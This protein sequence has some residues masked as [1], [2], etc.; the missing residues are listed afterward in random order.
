MSNPLLDESKYKY[1]AVPF[2]QLD[3]AVYMPALEK[4][5]GIARANTEAIKNDPAPP[6]FENTIL[7]LEVSSVEVNKV[8]M[9]Y[10]N[11][12]SAHGDAE[13]HALAKDMM[14][15]IVA[16]ESDVQLDPKL[17]A[18]IKTVH[19]N[20]SS[21]NAEQKMLTEKM[22]LD[23]KRNGA[24]LSDD[25]KAKL[26]AVDEELSTL[27]PQFSENMLKSTNEYFLHVTDESELGGLP[28]S[29]MSAAKDEAKSRKLEGWVFTCHM[30]SSIPFMTYADSAKLRKEMYMA[31]NTRA[32]GGE[33]D[34]SELVKKIAVLRYKRAVLLGYRNHADYTLEQRMAQSPEKVNEFIEYLTKVSRAPA[35]KELADVIAFKKEKTGSD[36]F[37]NWDMGY[38]ANKLKEEKFSFDSEVLRPYFKLEN[39]LEGVFK[40]AEALFDLKFKQI[41]SV[42]VYHEDVTVYEVTKVSDGSFMGLFYGDFFP[43]DTKQSGAWCTRF[44]AQ[45]K[46]GAE[47]IRPHASIVCNFTKPTADKPSLLT[48]GEVNTLFHEFGH[49]L[50]NLLSQVT[51][52]SMSCTNVYRDFVELPSQIFENWIREKES[53]SLFATHYETGELMPDEYIRKIK[54]SDNFLAATYTLRQLYFGSVDMAWFGTNPEKVQDVSAYEMEVTAQTRLMDAVPGTNRSCSFGHIFAGGYAAGYYG[55]KWAEVLDA[56]AFEFFKEEGIFSK[57]VAD[58]FRT[59]ILE[60]GGTAHPMDLYKAFRGREP[61]PE[62]LLRRCELI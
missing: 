22:Y 35:E 33:F 18:R 40:H 16:F 56:D 38:W 60:K 23:F 6:T 26:R 24:D 36:E 53:L 2:D 41:D 12:K 54:E 39:V 15:K 43:R 37:H 44:Q 3:V 47:N 25:E 62:A 29:S 34:N 48:L 31:N 17:F 11:L 49:A 8:A 19:E 20:N 30:P 21:L 59:C 1:G 42:P 5:L 45:W 27:S 13:M 4:A 28:E 10:F 61:D 52:R 58:K 32:I 7:A 14:P 57:K 55:Y 51:Y 9:V 46:E 50:H